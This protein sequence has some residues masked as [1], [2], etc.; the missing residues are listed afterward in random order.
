MFLFCQDS[1]KY[2]QWLPGLPPIYPLFLK[3][4][5]IFGEY[6]FIAAVILQSGFLLFAAWK[7]AKRF[8]FSNTGTK[9]AALSILTLPALSFARV[10]APDAL[11]YA[12]SLLAMASLGR[13]TYGPLALIS[14]AT[15]WQYAFLLFGLCLKPG[16]YRYLIIF[17]MILPALLLSGRAG[18]S[19][20][21]PT[22]NFIAGKEEVSKTN[23]EIKNGHDIY[24]QHPGEGKADLFNRNYVIIQPIE[25]INSV[26]IIMNHKL[27]FCK[28]IGSKL[29]EYFSFSQLVFFAILFISPCGFVR[30]IVVLCAFH[31]MEI[32]LLSPTNSWRY[33]FPVETVLAV[34]ALK[35]LDALV[36]RFG[37]GRIEA[38]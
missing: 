20:L 10:I 31:L 33:N 14:A 24:S 22:A 27:L 37:T 13:P 15:R 11:G 8:D 2:L 23:F 34:C 19:R 3:M 32:F 30:K 26:K 7:L 5:S 18:T 12:F 35:N 25:K 38:N 29:I 28:L 16:K 36:L 1:F 17:V 21:N 9:W 4:L 6:K